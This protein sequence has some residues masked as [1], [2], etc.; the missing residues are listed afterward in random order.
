M[1]RPLGGSAESIEPAEGIQPAVCARSPDPCRR[2]QFL[3]TTLRGLLQ[4]ADA[5]VT[6]CLDASPVAVMERE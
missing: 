4:P 5:Q 3:R 2:D 1:T 6:N